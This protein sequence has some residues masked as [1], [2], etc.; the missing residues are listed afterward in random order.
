[1]CHSVYIQVTCSRCL[2]TF[3]KRK[4]TIKSWKG[5]CFKC[6]VIK[7]KKVRV[8]KARPSGDKHYKWKGGCKRFCYIC[9]GIVAT[10][11]LK[12]T[13][14]KTCWIKSIVG[15]TK[16]KEVGDKISATKRMLFGTKYP[17]S[18]LRKKRRE[19]NTWHKL[20]FERDGNKCTNCGSVEKLEAHHIKEVCNYPE[21]IFDVDNGQTLCRE[22]HKK[23]DN[24]GVNFYNKIIHKFQPPYPSI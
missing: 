22:C 11:S 9:G 14:C 4:D 13:R 21:L 1:M 20:V 2:K 15:S 23:T 12:P 18:E 5:M 17:Q 8:H 16:P 7:T 19:Y 24:Y 6:S 3:D 10:R